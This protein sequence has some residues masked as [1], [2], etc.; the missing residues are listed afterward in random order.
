M[1]EIYDTLIDGIPDS[2]TVKDFAEGKHWMTV[3][4]SEGGLGLAMRIDVA[5]LH[6]QHERN[7]AGMP[8]K[9]LAEYAKSWNFI[10]A[11][12]GVAAINAWYNYEKRAEALGIEMPDESRKNEAFEKYRDQVKGKKVA[13]VGHFPFLENLLRPVCELVILERRPQEGDHPDSAC[14]FVL[15]E[16]DY[17][18]ITGAT[19]VNKTLPRLLALSKK[20][21]TVLVGPSVPLSPQIFDYGVD[22]LS[23][24]VVRKP[25]LCL[26]GIRSDDRFQHFQ[27]G[28]MVNYRK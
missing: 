9:R 4:S 16:Q 25:E 3:L 10:E 20:A 2:I 1:W 8:L 24:F 11:G 5:T 15:P 23:G 21:W 17:V 7:Y 13:V 22:D 12:F 27:A 6:L 18:F 28:T 26:E 19:M 14:E